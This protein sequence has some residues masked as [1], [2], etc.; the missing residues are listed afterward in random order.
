MK[1]NCLSGPPPFLTVTCRLASNCTT[2]WRD[3]APDKSTSRHDACALADQNRRLRGI[4]FPSWRFLTFLCK[5]CPESISDR[6][7]ISRLVSL[8]PCATAG[9]CLAELW[10]GRGMLCLTMRSGVPL[11]LSPHTPLHTHI[12]THFFPS[13]WLSTG[14]RFAD[15]FPTFPSPPRLLTCVRL[16]FDAIGSQRSG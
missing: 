4:L 7:T 1:K 8:G 12:S 11:P 5:T 10:E 15:L 9:C 16:L 13:C 3:P 2:C 6:T 14:V